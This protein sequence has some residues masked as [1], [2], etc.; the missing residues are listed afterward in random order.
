MAGGVTPEPIVSVPVV[1]LPDM[2]PVEELVEPMEPGVVEGLVMGS[3]DD[4]AFVASST[5]LPQAP[6]ASKA[7]KASAVATAG[8]NLDAYMSVFPFLNGF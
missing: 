7:D 2:A 6:S 4:G 8:F 3:G 1:V 5:F